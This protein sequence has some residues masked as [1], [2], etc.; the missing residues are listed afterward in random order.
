[1]KK[2]IRNLTGKNRTST[3][4]T[5]LGLILAF[6]AGAINAGG[7]LAIGYYTSHMT[8]IISSVGDFIALNNFTSALLALLY[9]FSFC[10]GAVVSAIVINLA[11][12]QNLKSE[13]ALV[14]MIE[15][16][17]LLVFGLFAAHLSNVVLFAVN[18]TIVLLCFIMGLQ[19]ALITKISG[20]VIRTTH[21]TGL[22]TDIG[23]EIG[24]QIYVWITKD[25]NITLHSRQMRLHLGLLA[26]FL[27]GGIFGALLF[28][29]IGFIA[30][31]PFA[32]LLSSLAIMPIVDDL[33]KTS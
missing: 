32:V 16:L 14:L 33:R 13:Y 17:L 7:F 21:V 29:W 19:N 12:R 15:A 3:S 26:A 4:D 28:K 18:L 9:L 27:V 5:Q 20:A 31:V 23:I 25:K 2:L 10:S 8:G 6:T 22:V 30:T 11:R 24:R 1:M